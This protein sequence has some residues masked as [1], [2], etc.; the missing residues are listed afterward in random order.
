[1]MFFQ[2]GVGLVPAHAWS[3]LY[4]GE[5]IRRHVAYD[6]DTILAKNQGKKQ[7]QTL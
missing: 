1:M 7:I 2:P 5:N 3:V 4:G 6:C